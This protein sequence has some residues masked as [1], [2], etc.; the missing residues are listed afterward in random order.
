MFK[1][2]LN[3]FIAC[4]AVPFGLKPRITDGENATPEEFPY[5]VSLQWGLPPLFR[6]RHI[7]GGSIVHESFILTAGHCIMEYGKL[8]VIV[9]KHYLYEDEETQQEVDVAKIYVHKNYSGYVYYF[10][11]QLKM[12]ISEIGILH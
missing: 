2:F 12:N 7:C 4:L 5:Q 10:Y 9:G 3:I 11:L 1:V 8:K 6:F